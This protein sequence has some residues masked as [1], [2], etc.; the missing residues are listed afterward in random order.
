M[1]VLTISIL[2]TVLQKL[3]RWHMK[4]RSIVGW[5]A[6]EGFFLSRT[7]SIDKVTG[8]SRASKRKASDLLTRDSWLYYYLLWINS[9]SIIILPYSAHSMRMYALCVACVLHPKIFEDPEFRLQLLEVLNA[10]NPILRFRTPN[11]RQT[12]RKCCTT[13]IIQLPSIA[14]FRCA[15]NKLFKAPSASPKFGL[16]ASAINSEIVDLTLYTFYVLRVM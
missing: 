10:D 14:S 12:N 4:K 13:R 6:F 7:R 2:I 15:V 11:S 16:A 3:D 1:N 5:P 9:W 8:S